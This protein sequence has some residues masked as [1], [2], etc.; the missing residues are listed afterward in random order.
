MKKSITAICLVSG[1]VMAGAGSYSLAQD[2]RPATQQRME[3]PRGHAMDPVAATQ[4][5]LD[6]LKQKLDLK[7]NQQA[8]WETF[9]KALLAR[10]TA[11][12]QSREKMKGAAGMNRAAIST[13]EK[14]EKIAVAMRTN[15]DNLSKAASDTKVFYD[16]LSVEQKTIFDLFSQNAW[17]HRMRGHFHRGPY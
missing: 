1:L 17:N 4:R 8:A 5:H 3:G 10:A 12:E 16:A 14:M 9:S 15:A 11:Q 7:P 13:P 6:K 2:A